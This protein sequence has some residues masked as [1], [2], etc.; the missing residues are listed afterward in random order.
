[1][2]L[3]VL[4]IAAAGALIAAWVFFDGPFLF[5][6]PP[7]KDKKF[8]DKKIRRIDWNTKKDEDVNT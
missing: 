4:G 2:I 3:Q 8:K 6:V 1:M 5:N 7:K